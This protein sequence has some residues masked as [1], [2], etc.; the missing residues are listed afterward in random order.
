MATTP[1]KRFPFVWYAIVLALIILA[2]TAPI[3]SVLISSMIAE[4]HGCT[5]NEGGVHPCVI[6]GQDWGET[7]LMMAMMGWLAIATLP[8]G[9][10]A[11]AI[12]LIVLIVHFTN[13][14]RGSQVKT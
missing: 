7:L 6:N 5:L 10:V 4:A 11:G 2:A 1:R 3:V 8:I 12:W 13:R 9:A 14:S